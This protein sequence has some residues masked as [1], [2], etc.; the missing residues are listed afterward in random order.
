MENEFVLFLPAAKSY[1][2]FQKINTMDLS[3]K[4]LGLELRIHGPLRIRLGRKPV[5]SA[6]KVILSNPTE[7]D[8][9]STALTTRLLRSNQ[10]PRTGKCFARCLTRSKGAVMTTAGSR[11]LG[12]TRRR[13]L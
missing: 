7:N 9:P 2:I 1:K 6:T 8:T 5:L 13:L 10:L 11:R 12:V 3:T 4:Y